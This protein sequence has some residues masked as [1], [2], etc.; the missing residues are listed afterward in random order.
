[1]DAY[2]RIEKKYRFE[3]PWEYRTARDLGW[4]DAG[5]GAMLLPDMEW[6]PLET[7]AEFEFPTYCRPHLS[8]L[9]PFA[10]SGGGDYWC[11]QA[12]KNARVLLCTHDCDDGLV[13]APD[14]RSALLRQCL[15][16][17]GAERST[18][19]EEALASARASLERW[20][21]DFA[22]ILPAQWCDLL[23]SLADHDTHVRETVTRGDGSRLQIYC[24]LSEEERAGIEA[25]ELGYPE[26]D[27]AIRWM[28]VGA[29]S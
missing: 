14:F 22:V 29:G 6:W 23:A 4:M 1:M 13:Y 3:I 15:E 5:K 26:L 12:D 8:G 9:V 17:A 10:S 16:C 21:R 11:W 25:I 18:G 27:A 2:E 28:H 24:L 7:I 20:S 19:V